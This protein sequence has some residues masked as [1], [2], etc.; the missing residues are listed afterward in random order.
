M[1]LPVKVDFKVH[2]WVPEGNECL[3]ADIEQTMLQCG[4]F[5]TPY[6]S[7]REILN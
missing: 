2:F 3:F 1:V 7:R 4:P 5:S 6:C